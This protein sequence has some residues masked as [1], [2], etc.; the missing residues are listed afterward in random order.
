MAKNKSIQVLGT[1]LTH[2]PAKVLKAI[3][4]GE[5][6]FNVSLPEDPASIFSFNHPH[7]GAKRALALNGIVKDKNTL[8]VFHRADESLERTITK[9]ANKDSQPRFRVGIDDT[10]IYFEDGQVHIPETI[11]FVELSKTADL[12]KHAMFVEVNT[13]QWV[14]NK[15]CHGVKAPAYYYRCVGTVDAV[16]EAEAVVKTLISAG[17]SHVLWPNFTHQSAPWWS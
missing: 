12:V 16:T 1:N 15:T 17:L 10:F 14:D 3:V 5:C 8:V 13:G 9:R 2:L 6:S 7:T 4:N 11:L